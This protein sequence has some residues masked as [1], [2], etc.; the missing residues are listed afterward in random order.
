VQAAS[1]GD[2]P[3][4][5]ALH[6]CGFAFRVLGTMMCKVQLGGWLRDYLGVLRFVSRSGW[7]RRGSVTVPQK[8][9]NQISARQ[10]QHVGS[11]AHPLVPLIPL[12]VT[13][14]LYPRS[15]SSH[16]RVDSRPYTRALFLPSR[17]A[18]VCPHLLNWKPPWLAHLGSNAAL[19]SAGRCR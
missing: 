6:H 3:L 17:R 7:Q 16:L 2:V 19:G 5:R 8:F 11:R 18:S 9:P 12:N 4:F 14:T 10:H 15:M 13:S 1:A